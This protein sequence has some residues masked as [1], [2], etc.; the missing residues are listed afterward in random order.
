MTG[1]IRLSLSRPRTILMLFVLLLVSGTATYLSIPRESSPDIPI[2]FVYV[3]VHHEGIS[4][5]DAERLL[6]FP[7]EKE[8]Q[9][10]SGIKE[11]KATASHSHASITIE[12]SAGTD[13]GKALSDV[14]DKVNLA[15]SKLPNGTDEPVIKEITMASA[16][17]VVTAILS[18][19][20]PERALVRTARAIKDVLEQ[21]RQIL[22]VDI[23]GDREEVVDIIVDPLKLESYGLVPA[24]VVSL[25]SNNNQLVAAGNLDTGS[26]RFSIKVPAVYKTPA[27]ILNQPI[28]VEQGRVVTF[29]DVATVLSTY[30]EG[31]A[32]ARLNGQSSVALEIKKR[33]GEN[34]IETVALARHIITEA[35]QQA[36]ETLT[37][38]YVGDESNDVRDMVTDLQNNVLSAVILVVIIIIGALGARSAFLVG[39]A[40]PG[41]FLSGILILGMMELTINMIVLFS[42]IMAVGMLVDGAIVVTEYADR[43]MSEGVHRRKAYLEA[44]NRMAWPIIASTATTLA[45]FFP[46]MFW[47]GTMGEFMKYLPLTLM[48]TLTSSLVMALVFIPT[49]GSLMGKTRT[50]SARE[51]KNLQAAEQGDWQSLSGFNGIYLKLLRKAVNNPI[52][53]LMTAFTTVGVIFWSFSNSSLGVEYFPDV[54]NNSITVTAR[55]HSGN[56][57]VDEKD[58]V[59][60]QLEAALSGVDEIESLYAK[61]GKDQVVG[62]L[63]ITLVGWQYRVKT[64]EIAQSLE[65]RL[66]DFHGL[67]I[68]VERKKDGPPKKKALELVIRANDL[69][70]LATSVEQ[71]K[72]LMANADVFLNIEDSG[73]APGYEWRL[74]IDREDAARLGASVS[75]TGSMVRLVTSGLVVG[76]YRPDDADDEVD[77]RIRFPESDRHLDT[78]SHLRLMT[79]AG[80]TPISNFSNMVINPKLDK[81]TR[82]NGQRSITVTAD[83]LDGEQLANHLPALLSNI[84]QSR[85]PDNV[86]FEVKGE[87]QELQESGIFLAKAFTVALFIMAIILVTQFN[88]FY[89]AGL[90]M[91]AVILATGGVFLAL[92]ITGQNFG[93]VMSGVGIIS[94]AG[95]VVNNNIVLIDTYNA[96][97]A[98]GLDAIEASLRT[99]AQ[100]LRPVL[101]T[102]ITTILGLM[103]MVLSVNINLFNHSIETG[104]PFTQI[105]NQL[106][107]AIAGGLAFATILT[108]VVTPAFLVLSGLRQDRKA[109]LEAA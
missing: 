90:I 99:G 93:I 102:T 47:P 74:D 31:G 96:L 95:I 85:L 86:S 79:N 1:F 55:V 62:I 108:L 58:R 92:M 37:V 33:S 72:K 81:I 6:V 22:E 89:Q 28:K 24:D 87:Q 65:Q 67:A 17:P 18:G 32:Y 2:P 106:A 70:S 16:S 43:R 69:T 82:L 53:T 52:K 50:L 94:L 107:T 63:N 83:L 21:Q 11:L 10:L 60:K 5:E 105:W 3:S 73:P 41:S 14:R 68:S 13:L 9:G 59:L 98:E 34:I 26:G 38:H 46:L 75:T 56:L 29:A 104:A 97:R 51:Q 66:S 91:S 4:P 23:A 30:K 84:R 61:T 27:D 76:N 8:L 42:L 19:P 71:V 78:I 48:A 45:A 12:F 64:Q 40:I 109:V 57:S 80:L 44:S 15:K 101:L 20:L 100:R 25:V 103:P 39:I 49:I 7:L 88:S 35:M 77:I 54:D 36:P